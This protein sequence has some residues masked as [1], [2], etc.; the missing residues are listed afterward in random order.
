MLNL[1]DYEEY[2][3]KAIRQSKRNPLQLSKHYL[4][5]W[6]KFEKNISSLD[7]YEQKKVK[8]LFTTLK[9]MSVEERIFLA[10]KYR[11][12]LFGKMGRSDKELADE[13]NMTIEEYTNLRRGV[14]YKFFCKLVETSE[15][16]R[17]E[18]VNEN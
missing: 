5:K 12:I 10:T 13:Y 3:T 9:A 17:T 1:K 7:I 15:S 14:E 18:F 2:K 11:V 6:G 4:S 16:F 8:R